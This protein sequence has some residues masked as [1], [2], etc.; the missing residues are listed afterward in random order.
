M[1]GAPCHGVVELGT[2]GRSWGGG[3][4][5]EGVGAGER[6]ASGWDGAGS[7]CCTPSGL[8]HVRGDGA[9]CLGLAGR[10][11]AELA[12]GGGNRREDAST[13]GREDVGRRASALALLG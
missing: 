2:G 13:G 9:S 8:S 10:T 6:K 5:R 1:V 7:S 4:Q 12:G 11:A 3:R